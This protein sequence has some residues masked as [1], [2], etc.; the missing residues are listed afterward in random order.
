[1]YVQRKHVFMKN[2]H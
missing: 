1:M 2:C